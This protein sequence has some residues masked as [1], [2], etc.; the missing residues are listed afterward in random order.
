MHTNPDAMKSPCPADAA[1]YAALLPQLRAGT[2]SQPEQE[3][4]R[5]HLTRCAPCR[6]QAARTADQVV[7]DAVRQHYGAPAAEAPFLT[8]DAIRRRAS[9]SGTDEVV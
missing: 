2:L 3:A 8:L 1:I 9:L 5:R 4:L 7:E 6:E